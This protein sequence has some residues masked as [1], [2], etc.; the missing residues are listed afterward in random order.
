ML[1]G[2]ILWLEREERGEGFFH[3]VNIALVVVAAAAEEVRRGSPSLPPPVIAL[4][5]EK[6]ESKSGN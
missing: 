3:G 4:S 6:G 2:L 1:R 5:R